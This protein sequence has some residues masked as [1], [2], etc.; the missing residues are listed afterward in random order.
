[1][2]SRVLTST[3]AVGSSRIRMSRF[4]DQRPGQ[5]DALLLAAGEVADMPSAEPADPKPLQRLRDL[6]ASSPRRPGQPPHP[7]DRPISTT[8]STVTGKVQSTVSTCG[9]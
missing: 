4:A 8:S 1:M 7:A 2:S 6:A 9:T 3:L 5:E